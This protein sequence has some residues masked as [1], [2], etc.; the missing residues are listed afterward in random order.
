MGAESRS[1]SRSHSPRTPTLD[2]IMEAAR[3]SL[4][5]LCREHRIPESHGYGHA[6]RVLGHAEQAMQASSRDLSAAQRLSVSLASLLHD[7]DDRKY[8]PKN[9]KGEF[10][11]AKRI[12]LDAGAEAEVVEDALAMIA[13]VSCSKNGN[14]VP[15]EAHSRPELLWPR[16][17]DRLEATGEI[18]AV[19]C[20]QYNEELGRDAF[21]SSTPRPRSEAEVWELATPERFEKYQASGGQSASMIDHYFDKLLRVARPPT[22]VLHNDYFEAEMVRRVA[23]LVQ[24]C[25]AFGETGEVPMGMLRSWAKSTAGQEH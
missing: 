18:G 4:Q 15:P 20:W 25:L 2:P 22:E 17:A 16:W 13:L 12:M 24:V 9:P 23:P 6:L 1:R 3:E 11:N 8:F 21:T 7:V 19:R 5:D 10:P 14:S